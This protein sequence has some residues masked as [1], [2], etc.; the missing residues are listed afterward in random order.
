MNDRWQQIERLYHSALEKDGEARAV[1]LKE[2]CEGDE[3]LLREVETLLFHG[4]RNGSFLKGPAI[5]A[6]AK[7]M[8]KE[9]GETLVGR[10]VGP[11]EVTAQVG[12]GGMGVVYRAH[13]SKLGRDI[14]IKTLPREFARDPDRLARFRREARM[15][16]SLNHP[17]IA[18]IYGLEESRSEST[19]LNSSHSQISYA[20]FCLK[21]KKKID[22][23]SSNKEN[24]QDGKID[25]H[26][27]AS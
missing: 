19:R 26:D 4:D 25:E 18:A 16:A 27:D 24:K 8:G 5:E 10:Q 23:M 13:D 3:M 7:T 15:L 14:A 2:A 22:R 11:Y 20:V 21:K 9:N 1:F 6:V 12:A 17:N